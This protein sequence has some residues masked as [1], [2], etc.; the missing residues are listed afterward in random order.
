MK[1]L[2]LLLAA[3][4]VVSCSKDAEAPVSGASAPVRIDPTITRAT[5]VDFEAGDA[6]GLTIVTTEGTT[7]AA[8]AEM[9]FSD[10]AFVSASGLLWY[11]DLGMTSTMK[12]YYPYA[13]TVPTQF[14]V[15]ADQTADGFGA[16]DL[17]M[18]KKEGVVPSVN[19]I[20]MTFKHK[21]TKLVI[22]IENEYG[23]KVTGVE[24]SNSVATATV[25]TDAQTVAVK[26][27]AE[28]VK[29]RAKEV[30]AGTKYAAILVPQTAALR[31]DVICDNSGKTEVHTQT[32]TASTLQSGAQYTM[33]ITVLPSEVRVSLS[34]DIEDWGNG[35]ELIGEDVVLFEEF[36][37]HFVYYGE[38][39]KIVTLADGN[40]WMAENMRYVPAGK[41]VSS[42]PTA[43]AGIWYSYNLEWSE[44]DSKYKAIA[45]PTCSKGLLYNMA[46]ILG[47]DEV[48][49][50]NYKSFEGA[51]GIC[52]KGWHVPT[53]A[54]G[55]NLVGYSTKIEGES[56]PVTNKEAAYYDTEYNGGK[57]SN[58]TDWDFQFAGVRLKTSD[59]MTGS[60]SVVSYNKVG[61]PTMNYV[62]TSTGSNAT[63]TI[64]F[65]A[66]MTTFTSTLA[67]GRLSLADNVSTNG[68]ALRCVKN[69]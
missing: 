52:P 31:V 8:N 56:G 62:A 68:V 27:G 21:M 6:V 29:I 48:T 66:F 24:I 49:V 40:T 15:A 23:L 4:A 36:D 54:E 39:Y 45:D 34:G 38:T 13:E 67:D 33:H 57:L 61:F 37:D 64:K 55:L 18:A 16:S 19:A 11:D 46:T 50:D 69:K 59:K 41:T 5:E 53:R 44:A 35:G 60:Y 12:A 58:M 63:S 7:H 30:A 10:G 42:D 28:T 22:E 1:K 65:S 3:C 43:D 25:D 14:S 2:F 20:G 17:M 51:Q 47:V 32:L 9:T 26:E